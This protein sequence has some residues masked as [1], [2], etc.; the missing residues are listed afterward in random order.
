MLFILNVISLFQPLLIGFS[1]KKS[2]CLRT[3]PR[4]NVN[5]ANVVSLSGCCL[6][7]V[8]ELCYLAVNTAK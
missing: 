7:W 5:C 4:C 2:F 8:S 3:G 1:F 6:S